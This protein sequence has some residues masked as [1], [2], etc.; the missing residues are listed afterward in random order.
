MNV[1]L[2]SVHLKSSGRH[3]LYRTALLLSIVLGLQSNPA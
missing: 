2:S 3:N 1:P